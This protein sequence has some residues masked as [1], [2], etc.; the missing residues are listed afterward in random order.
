MVSR[1]FT[2]RME[3]NLAV[4]PAVN[5]SLP[6]YTWINL[7]GVSALLSVGAILLTVFYGVV[8]LCM[9]HHRGCTA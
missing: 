1:H 4:L 9:D 7:I 2:R 3:D 6:S 8:P 5:N